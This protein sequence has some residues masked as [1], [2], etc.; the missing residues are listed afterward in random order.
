MFYIDVGMT[1]T[2]II[3][4]IKI[5]CILNFFSPK[6]F[7]LRV[8]DGVRIN[9][10][11]DNSYT[12]KVAN[13][14]TFEIWYHAFMTPTQKGVERRGVL[15]FITCLQTL[16]FLSNIFIVHFADGDGGWGSKCWPFFVEILN[17]WSLWVFFLL[18]KLFFPQWSAAEYFS[19][20]HVYT[21]LYIN[22]LYIIS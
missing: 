11:C 19:L 4:A 15:K 22:H 8:H 16:L 1:H 14:K 3:S 12:L 20:S 5:S 10:L 6:I 18:F 2:R 17:G 9:H 13:K 21:D 7:C